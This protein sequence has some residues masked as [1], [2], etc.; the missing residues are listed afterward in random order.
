MKQFKTKQNS[1]LIT[2]GPVVDR[3]RRGAVSDGV[4]KKR[5][6]RTQAEWGGRLAR[7]TCRGF[8]QV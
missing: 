5:R 3:G 8:P 7:D 6:A 2:V 1:I 4:E